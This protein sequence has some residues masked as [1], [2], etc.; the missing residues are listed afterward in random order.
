MWQVKNCNTA[1]NFKKK[2]RRIQNAAHISSSNLISH[3]E[4]T[5]ESK[6]SHESNL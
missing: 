4:L 1:P 5:S 2:K 3:S 6:V